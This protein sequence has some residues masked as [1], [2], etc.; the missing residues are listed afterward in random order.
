MLLL[1]ACG[2]TPSASV[3]YGDKNIPVTIEEISKPE[4]SIDSRDN[5]EWFALSD[6][7]T[8][9]YG[10]RAVTDLVY[11]PRN[12]SYS[13]KLTGVKDD[14]TVHQMEGIYFYDPEQG[15][16]LTNINPPEVTEK[17]GSNFNTIVSHSIHFSSGKLRE[18]GEAARV[19]TGTFENSG[20]YYRYIFFYR[21][22]EF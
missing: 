15:S 13:I 17:Q 9:L 16:G 8:E 10:D 4:K 7:V 14:V 3:S 18:P 11:I 6:K 19:V 21:T 2:K 22:D 5:K 20:K 1:T 12:E